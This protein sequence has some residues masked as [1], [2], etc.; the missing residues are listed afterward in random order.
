MQCK[1]QEPEQFALENLETDGAEQPAEARLA[2][3][4]QKVARRQLWHAD[5]CFIIVFVGFLLLGPPSSLIRLPVSC[6]IGSSARHCASIVLSNFVGP[7]QEAHASREKISCPFVRISL[8]SQRCSYCSSFGQF[9]C[10]CWF[11]G[12]LVG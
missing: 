12:S 6:H 10:N 5:T 11:L 4:E 1:D 2:T 3:E 8:E 9:L 7:V